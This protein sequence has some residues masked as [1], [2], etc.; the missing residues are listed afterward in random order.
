MGSWSV[1]NTSV[2]TT[3]APSANERWEIEYGYLYLNT[4]STAAVRQVSLVLTNSLLSGFNIYL[5]S[6]GNVSGTSTLYNAYILPYPNLS[7]SQIPANSTSANQFLFNYATPPNV[8]P[9]NTL[10]VSTEGIQ[11]GDAWS[12]QLQYNEVAL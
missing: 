5:M 8:W 12:I 11:S 4:N 7:S 9:F 1:N 10:T 3:I 2:N 6:T